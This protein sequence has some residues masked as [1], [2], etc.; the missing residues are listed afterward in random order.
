MKLTLDN[1]RTIHPTAR[2]ERP[3]PGRPSQH[4]PGKHE[5]GACDDEDR[6]DVGEED[7]EKE[8]RRLNHAAL[9]IVNSQTV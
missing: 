2:W 8:L 9:R 4:A 3:A 6:Q 7:L 1:E 5:T